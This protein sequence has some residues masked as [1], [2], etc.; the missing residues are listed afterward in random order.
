MPKAN[1]RELTNAI[2]QQKIQ[3]EV[4]RIVAERLPAEADRA[5]ADEVKKATDREMQIQTES[6]QNKAEVEARKAMEGQLLMTQAQKD[7]QVAKARQQAAAQVAANRP[8]IEASMRDKLQPAVEATVRVELTKRVRVRRWP[9]TCP[10]RPPPKI[11][12]G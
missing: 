5:L 3:E 10:L 4:D 11:S 12:S 6:A 9:P 1:K 2:K 8:K 7:Q